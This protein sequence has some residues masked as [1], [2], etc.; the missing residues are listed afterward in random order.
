MAGLHK[1]AVAVDHSQVAWTL[2][3]CCMSTSVLFVYVCLGGRNAQLIFVAL[4]VWFLLNPCSGK[5]CVQC[6]A[7]V[8]MSVAVIRVVLGWRHRL[9]PPSIYQCRHC[10]WLVEPLLHA[11]DGAVPVCSTHVH[12]A[13]QD[14]PSIPSKYCVE[15]LIYMSRGM[16]C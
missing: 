11:C 13:L 2:V 16:L 3:L 15:A 10:W 1:P 9:G 6:S 7:A 4:L 5:R 14:V 8:L 12:K